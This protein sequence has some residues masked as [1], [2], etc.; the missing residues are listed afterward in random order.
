MHII[1]KSFNGCI[2]GNYLEDFI[3]PAGYKTCL[4]YGSA[5]WV[6]L[7]CVEW[8]QAGHRSTVL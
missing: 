6:R 5:L 8:S 3:T 2:A 7:K 1:Y 4:W